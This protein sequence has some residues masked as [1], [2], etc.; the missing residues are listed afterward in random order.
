MQYLFS[1][2]QT[3]NRADSR[4]ETG[5]TSIAA[6]TTAAEPATAAVLHAA[7]LSELLALLCCGRAPLMA[8]RRFQSPPAAPRADDAS[9]WRS[10]ALRRRGC[11]GY[12]RWLPRT[13]APANARSVASLALVAAA[14][15]ANDGGGC[16]TTAVGAVVTSLAAAPVA[17]DSGQRGCCSQYGLG[18]Q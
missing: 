9:I 3:T 16:C 12:A 17:K 14:V 2:K 7:G 5:R 11:S 13:P 4:H 6:V 10:I 15:A 18:T 8:A 1:G